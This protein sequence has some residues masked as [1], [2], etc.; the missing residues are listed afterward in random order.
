MYSLHSGLTTLS[1]RIPLPLGRL[2]HTSNAGLTR[3][4]VLAVVNDSAE[5]AIAFIEE[6]NTAY[7]QRK[8]KHNC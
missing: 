7:Q 2:N 4:H 3:V 6:F 8:R 1:F 5:R